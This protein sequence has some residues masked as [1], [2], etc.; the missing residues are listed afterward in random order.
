MKLKNRSAIITGGGGGIGKAIA[1]EFSNNGCRCLISDINYDAASSV[2]LE[3]NDKGGEAIAM[4][5]DVSNESEVLEMVKYGIKKFQKI[6]ILVTVAGVLSN[7]SFNELP[8]EQWQWIK[9][10][11][12]DGTFYCVK[13]ILPEMIKNNYGRIITISSVA[14]IT[15]LPRCS[16][17]SAMKG[18]IIGLTK[19]VAKEVVKNNITVN[20]VAPGPI[21]TKM[22]DSLGEDVKKMLVEQTPV[23]RL[24]KP[25]DVAYWC[26]YLASEASSFTTGQIFNVSGG[27]TIN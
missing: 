25:N 1:Q 9:S 6:D 22:N 5:T 11:H 17:Y 24:G 10:V 19:S 4:K 15:G 23:G 8:V 14:G 18:V 3:I 26:L 20:S 27:Y 13:N 2:A 12:S 16:H 21:D 7:F